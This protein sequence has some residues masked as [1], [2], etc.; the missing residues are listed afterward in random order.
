MRPTGGSCLGKCSSRKSVA[1]PLTMAASLLPVART[2]KPPPLSPRAGQRRGGGRRF[3]HLPL[4]GGGRLREA[5]SGGGHGLEIVSSAGICTR[6]WR[7]DPA[8]ASHLRCSPTLPLQGRVKTRALPPSRRVFA[9]E[10]CQRH[11]QNL[12]LHMKE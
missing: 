6:R 11:S 8:P 3:L 7:T 12:C 10:L 9:P 5:Q 4:K 1:G 2:V